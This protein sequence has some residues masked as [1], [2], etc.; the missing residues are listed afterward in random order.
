MF[1]VPESH[2]ERERDVKAKRLPSAFAVTSDNAILF[3]NPRT[4]S[5]IIHRRVHVVIFFT[6]KISSETHG[7]GG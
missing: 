3:N 2:G 6:T 4:S 1:Y 7:D 5:N